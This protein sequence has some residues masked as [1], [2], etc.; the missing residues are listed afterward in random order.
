MKDDE[1]GAMEMLVTLLVAAFAI[2]LL[3]EGVL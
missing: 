3:L 2:A 1:A